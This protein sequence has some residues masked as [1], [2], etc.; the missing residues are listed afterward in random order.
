MRGTRYMRLISWT[1]RSGSEHFQCPSTKRGR[2][3]RLQR[4]YC[5]WCHVGYL[6]ILLHCVPR[7]QPHP[8]PK[9]ALFSAPQTHI[10]DVTQFST[11]KTTSACR[12]PPPSGTDVVVVLPSRIFFFFR[13]HL[14]RSIKL[15]PAS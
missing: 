3:C 8:F 5:S 10:R 13:T 1:L 6:H 14:E 2:D 4:R 12:K 11:M 7:H 9:P 15:V